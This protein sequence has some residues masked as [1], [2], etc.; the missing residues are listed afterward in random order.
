MFHD[1]ETNNDADY[2]VIN[3]NY[4]HNYSDKEKFDNH[5][6][7]P[8]D[9][10]DVDDDDGDGHDGNSRNRM[11]SSAYWLWYISAGCIVGA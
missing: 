7:V 5:D 1:G 4:I 11:R 9:D 3:Y 6:L 10:N 2:D 8:N